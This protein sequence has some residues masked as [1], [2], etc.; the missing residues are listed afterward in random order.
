MS[1]TIPGKPKRGRRTP[2]IADTFR[3]DNQ[4]LRDGIKALIGLSDEGALIPH[5]IGGHAR[6]LLAA[7]Y[8]RLKTK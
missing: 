2:S 6:T 3:G 4:Q 8:H 5:G 7:C 1:Q